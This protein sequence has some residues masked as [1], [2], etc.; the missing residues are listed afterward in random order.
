MPGQG[1]SQASWGPRVKNQKTVLKQA[2]YYPCVHQSGPA[3]SLQTDV[4]SSIWAGSNGKLG[5]WV[6]HFHCKMKTYWHHLSLFQFSKWENLIGL[7]LGTHLWSNKLHPKSL[8]SMNEWGN[9]RQH[10]IFFAFI[11]IHM[12]SFVYNHKLHMYIMI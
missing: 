2:S 1:E 3:C 12:I 9:G 8:F 11:Y 6:S 5:L 4:Q 10:N 7:H